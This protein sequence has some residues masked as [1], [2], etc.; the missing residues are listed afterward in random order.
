MLAAGLMFAAQAE[1][2]RPGT[3]NYIEGQVTATDT[4]SAWCF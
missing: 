3:V 2:G 4:P 1:M